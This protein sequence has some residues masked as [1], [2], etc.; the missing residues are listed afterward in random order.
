ME[1]QGAGVSRL[2]LFE[3]AHPPFRASFMAPLKNDFLR[4]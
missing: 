1:E 4:L 3:Q 2:G